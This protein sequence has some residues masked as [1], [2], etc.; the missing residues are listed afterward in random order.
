M[1]IKYGELAQLPERNIGFSIKIN[2]LQKQV[3]EMKIKYGELAQLPE[4]NIGFSI[5]INH[6]QKQ[7][8]EKPDTQMGN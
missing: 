6:L 7:V 8:R 2:H 5:K 3:R 4:R 1:K